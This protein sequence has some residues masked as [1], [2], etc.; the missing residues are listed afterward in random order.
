MTAYVGLVRN[1]MIGRQGLH[2]QVLVDLATAAGATQ[3]RSH[4]ATGNL[5][6]DV[7]GRRLTS[8]RS[9]LE[10]GIADVV[11]H[12]E[13]VVLR[14]QKRLRAF[15]AGLTPAVEARPAKSIEVALLPHDGQPLDP[16]GLPDPGA[17]E[18]L[19]VSSHEL[20]VARRD[21]TSPH[22]NHLMERG[23]ATKATARA[24]S[25]LRRLAA[26]EVGA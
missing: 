15:V 8:F 21:V 5:T 6:F 22:V 13:P 18:L 14:T 16:S 4:L 23:A 19:L 26:V 24:W 17:T 2:R 25:T 12:S 3:V 10:V 1:V 7:D 11:G 20:V 9:Q